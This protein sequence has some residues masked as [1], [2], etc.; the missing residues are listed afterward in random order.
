MIHDLTA[1]FYGYYRKGKLN[2]G[3]GFFPTSHQFVRHVVEG[4]QV[5]PTP[6]GRQAGQALADSIAAVNGKAVQGP[7]S[8]LRSAARY[9]QDE[10]YGIPVL[11]LSIA[12]KFDPAV[13]RSL[14]EGYFELDGT[15]IQITCTTR[16][17]LLA[18]KENPDA[19]QDLIVRIGGYSEYFCRL[20]PA[21]Q[22]AVIARTLFE[23]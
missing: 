7:T 22:D 14:I 11:N 6:D 5:G 9:A 23:S 12:Q 1:K 16:E 10:V 15:Q 13:L 3:L 21:L 18:A 8:M 19:H 4:R 20:D 17:T 2:M